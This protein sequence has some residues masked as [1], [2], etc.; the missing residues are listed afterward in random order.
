[1][2]D[3]QYR[4]YARL[5][6]LLA[7]LPLLGAGC[8]PWDNFLIG[9]GLREEEPREEELSPYERELRESVRRSVETPLSSPS[10]QAS[11]TEDLGKTFADVGPIRTKPTPLPG[12]PAPGTKRIEVIRYRGLLLPV[13]QLHVGPAQEC[14]EKHWHANTGT[15]IPV[16]GT[17]IRDPDPEECGFGTVRE[18]PAFETDVSAN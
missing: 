2:L 7:A 9:V 13:S 8:E 1:M 15:V 3:P 4:R 6:V 5:L 17:A 16:E 12:S 14:D 11:I 10:D 18:N